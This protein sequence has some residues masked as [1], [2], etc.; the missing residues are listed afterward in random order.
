MRHECIALRNNKEKIGYLFHGKV[1]INA[2]LG[3]VFFSSAFLDGGSCLLFTEKSPFLFIKKNSN[4]EKW[5]EVDKN[6]SKYE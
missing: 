1:F 2:L 6:N 3:S 4:N 5:I